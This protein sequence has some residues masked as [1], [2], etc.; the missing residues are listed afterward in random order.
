M[1]LLPAVEVY[2]SLDGS[3]YDMLRMAY[4]ADVEH[5]QVGMMACSPDGTGC[6][7]TFEEFSVRT[8]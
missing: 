8:P 4:L 3:A 5:V 6:E 2:Y 7:V 1:A